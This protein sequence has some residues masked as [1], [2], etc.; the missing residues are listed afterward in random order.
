MEGLIKDFAMD[1]EILWEKIAEN[2]TKLL[3]A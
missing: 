3:T 2:I 1:I